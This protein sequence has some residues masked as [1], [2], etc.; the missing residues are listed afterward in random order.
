[1]KESTVI[2]YTC[3]HCGFM[4]FEHGDGVF[5]KDT[6]ES[7]QEHEDNCFYDPKHKK[8]ATCINR[9]TSH[10]SNDGVC[11]LKTNQDEFKNKG[12]FVSV[13]IGDS[14]DKWG[15]N[16]RV[17]PWHERKNSRE[18][19]IAKGDMEKPYWAE[20][21]SD[22]DELECDEPSDDIVKCVCIDAWKSDDDDEEGKVIAK[23]ILTKS[24]DRGVV[25]IDNMARGLSQ[26][27]EVIQ[28]VLRE[29]KP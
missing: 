26:A 29:I 20:L 21:K 8:C 10:L 9:A 27:Q 11:L 5:N 23:V 25:Y 28:K 14:C 22:Y 19:K 18:M 1:M 4:T 6:K 7:A 17:A 16:T 3:D 12:F 24:G 15:L 13:C 2:K